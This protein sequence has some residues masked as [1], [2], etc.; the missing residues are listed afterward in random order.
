MDTYCIVKT[1]AE[2]SHH[3]TKITSRHKFYE[4]TSNY[5]VTSILAAYSRVS[6][7]IRQKHYVLI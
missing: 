5:S 7:Y 1:A 4:K 6:I 3:A 2:S